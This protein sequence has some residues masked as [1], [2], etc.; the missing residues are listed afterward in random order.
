MNTQQ[1]LYMLKSHQD[2][3]DVLMQQQPNNTQLLDDWL[4]ITSQIQN[5]EQLL[6]GEPTRSTRDQMP[7]GAP[8][9]Q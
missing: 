4:A 3:L 6:A 7:P 8:D 9:V 5:L 1:L 2:E